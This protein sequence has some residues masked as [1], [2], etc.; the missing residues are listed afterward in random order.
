MGGI[1]EGSGRGRRCCDNCGKPGGV[2]K[3]PCT[4]KVLSNS[5]HSSDGKR[6]ALPYCPPPALCK[7]CFDRLGKG[8]GVHASCA[9]GA[10]ASQARA[11]AIEAALDAGDFLP[12]SAYGDWHHTVPKGK[13]GVIYRGRRGTRYALVSDDDYKRRPALSQVDYEEWEGP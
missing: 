5:L 7:D 11:D 10:A 1:Y 9:E 8:K 12:T 2:R 3:R 4:H 13:V 6:H